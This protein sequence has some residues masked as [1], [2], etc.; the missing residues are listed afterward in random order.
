MAYTERIKLWEGDAPGHEEGFHDPHIK[1]FAP[2]GTPTGAA[3]ITFAGGGYRTRALYECESYCELLSER[4]IAAF[5]V[6]YRVKPTK[7]PYPLLDARRAV[8]F[9]RANAEKYG[10]DPSRIAVMGSSAG[11][12]LAA[13][14]STYTAPIDGEGVDGMDS[15]DF[16]P[17]AQ[18]LCYPVMDSYS[19]SASYANLLREDATIEDKDRV[20]PVLLAS[21]STPPAFIW[22]TST[23]KCVDMNGSMRYAVRLHELSVSVELHV[24][25]VGGHGLGIGEYAEKNIDVPYVKDWVGLLIK[26]L[27]HIGYLEPAK[28][29]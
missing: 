16:L 5:D 2:K 17:N 25:P 7:F 6:E 15:F 10:I 28:E 8:R 18:I 9:V 1:Y 13:L 19:H 24:Y 27:G 26:W 12:H 3:V 29:S 23:D 22:H 4:G 11:G 21:E 20:N 14:V